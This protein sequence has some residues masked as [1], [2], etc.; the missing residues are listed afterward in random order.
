MIQ[1]LQK[2]FVLMYLI[3][4]LS[5]A[6]DI[7]DIALDVVQNVTGTS[8]DMVSELN[9]SNTEEFNNIPNK[10]LLEGEAPLMVSEFQEIM[11]LYNKSPSDVLQKIDLYRRLL[12]RLNKMEVNTEFL[13]GQRDLMKSALRYRLGIKETADKDVH[14]LVV[15]SKI[16]SVRE[17]AVKMLISFAYTDG[18]KQKIES[19][20]KSYGSFVS[21]EINAHADII[22]LSL[23]NKNTIEESNHLIENIVLAP[24]SSFEHDGFSVRVLNNIQDNLSVLDLHKSINFSL[25]NES[26]DIALYLMRILIKKQNIDYNTLVT[27]SQKLGSYERDLFEFVKIYQGRSSVYKEYV[28]FYQNRI[29]AKNRGRQFHRRLYAY[30]GES[31]APYNSS[32]S[33]Q[34]LDEY[35]KGSVEPEYLEKNAKRSFRNFLAYKKYDILISS[36]QQ[37]RKKMGIDNISPYI[38]FWESYSLLKQGYTNEAIPLLG[39][40]LSVAPESY[41]GIL[42]QKKLKYIFSLIPSASNKYF[43]ELKKQS[44]N[45]KNSLLAYAHVLYYIGNRSARGY[46]EKIFL[47]EGLI[48]SNVKKTPT[49]SKKYLIEAYLEL[50]LIKN[51]RQIAYNDDIKTIYGQD[52]VL[53]NYYKKMNY[54][55]GIM[56]LVTQRS[57]MISKRNSYTIGKEALQIYFP[58]PYQEYFLEISEK[59]ERKMDNYLL[60]S[61]MR[62]ES[63]YKE[64]AYSRAG[65]RGLMQI[66][67]VTGKWLVDRYLPELQ[68]Y[69]LYTPS[70]NI[71]LGSVYMYDNIQRM[72][73]LPAIAAYNSG[74]TFVRNLSN[75]YRPQ[76]DL[77]LVEIHPKQETRNYVKKVIESYTRYSYIYNN[78]KTPLY[79][80]LS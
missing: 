55:S 6:Q 79:K 61:V 43:Y 23:E 73:F 34:I 15:T 2:Y 58:T 11:S 35:V 64:N 8:N 40:I 57:H 77:E 59:S 71:Y 76:T 3:I 41:Y 26:T 46:A 22:V 54:M 17:D 68:K 5:A 56:D 14:R 19:F 1:L 70:I 4:F 69:S 29:I 47:Q 74:P 32:M 53:F 7:S 45:D 33:Q 31:K 65:A 28:E 25:Y 44:T 18:N 80:N 9:I 72:G 49:S 63:F 38:N 75:K 60:Y 21:S 24:S 50:G 52:V 67:P 13:V 37:M 27:W 78:K 48:F 10:D 36:A 16:A 30:R 66:M 39:D 42:A 62:T 12:V 51:T 20:M